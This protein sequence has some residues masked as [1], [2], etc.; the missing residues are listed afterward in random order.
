[1]F[2][3]AQLNPR[4]AAALP[5]SN[6]PD[7]ESGFAA[8]ATGATASTALQAA[9]KAVSGLNLAPDEDNAASTG[10]EEEYVDEWGRTRKGVPPPRT[11]S[12]SPSP[13]PGSRDRGR[14][15]GGR[16]SPEDIAPGGRAI[17]QQGGRRPAAGPYN[18]SG[19]RLPQSHKV[20]VG[21]LPADATEDE[22]WAYFEQI[23]GSVVEVQIPPP[24]ED[25]RARKFG[26]VTFKEQLSAD[27]VA[28]GR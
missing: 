11:R 18:P 21:G 16:N 22:L 6:K 10:I 14:K 7:G 15:R 27:A 1:M 19:Q 13:E 8:E 2:H 12:R 9:S 23:G 20:F 25:G 17:F 26:F 28:V 24:D 3:L 5:A 4:P